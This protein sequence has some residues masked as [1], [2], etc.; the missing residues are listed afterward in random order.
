MDLYLYVD[1]ESPIHRMDPRAKMTFFLG[2]MLVIVSTEHPLIPG[3]AMLFGLTCTHIAGA[4]RSLKRVRM[5]F[6][7]LSLFSLITWS[8]FAQGA[9]PL[10]DPIELESVLYGLGTALKLS[11]TIT[12]AVLFLATTKN[13]EIAT[14]LIR[15]GIPYGVAFAFSTA[16]RLVPTFVGAG[17]T[18][19][20]AQKSRGLDVESGSIIARM[21]KYLPLVVPI[22]A[23]AIRS[24]NQLSMALE[25]KGFGA[26]KQR[27]LYL[28][29]R[30]RPADWIV[31]LLGYLLFAAYVWIRITGYGAIP[32]LLKR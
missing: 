31:T 2:L 1:R 20:Q 25:S 12:A 18:I 26:R 19:V 30:L 23:S 16:L 7:I 29:L 8:F 5:L 24:T 21:R 3:L 17:A 28:V 6:V 9:T 14:G 22:F 4:W 13:E 15:M 11:A 27:T 10:L 32:G